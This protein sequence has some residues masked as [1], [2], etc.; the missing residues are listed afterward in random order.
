MRISELIANLGAS[1]NE[2]AIA[3]LEAMF[4][5]SVF[6]LLMHGLPKAK[7]GE[8]LAVDGSASVTMP[9]VAGPNGKRMIKACADPDQFSVPA[10]SMSR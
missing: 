8:K 1:D 4:A 3:Q 7:P 2:R 9:V 10:P 6:G 5:E